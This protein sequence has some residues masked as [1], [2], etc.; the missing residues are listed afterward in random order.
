MNSVED[1]WIDA[2][3]TWA[4]GTRTVQRV[5]IVGSRAKGTA[6]HDSDLDVALTLTPSAGNTEWFFESDRW[7][8]ELQKLLDVKLHLLRGSVDLGNTVVATA[9]AEHGMLVFERSVMR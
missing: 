2:I 7:K 8:E 4:M 9:V 6:R 3:R 5:Y 1:R